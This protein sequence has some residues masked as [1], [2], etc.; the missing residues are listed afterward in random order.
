MK[1]INVYTAERWGFCDFIRGTGHLMNLLKET[2]RVGWLIQ[3]PLRDLLEF[4]GEYA[5]DARR[6]HWDTTDGI[7][8][9][10][11]ILH[12]HPD[13]I[14]IVET[15]QHEGAA[16]LRETLKD[17]FVLKQPYRDRFENFFRETVGYKPY[18]VVHCRFGDAYLWGGGND[19]SA[20][21]GWIAELEKYR[22][23][24]IVLLTDDGDFARCV[25]RVR[26][27]LIVPNMN[28]VHVKGC[29]DGEKLLR[30]LFDLLILT[31]ARKIVNIHQF[32]Q[33]VSSGFSRVPA[34]LF[35]IPFEVRKIK[36]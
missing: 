6:V 34:K 7:N 13:S 36:L 12:A 29:D 23:E 28:P 19:Q 11:G 33:K 18:R 2:C 15:N 24:K 26:P 8:D 5:D 1:V 35:G 20:F 25:R 32:T 31:R 30:T 17:I 10:S 9:L 21:S 14:V 3:S 16:P 27:E 22:S 4:P